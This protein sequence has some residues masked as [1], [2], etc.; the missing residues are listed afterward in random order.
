[1]WRLSHGLGDSCERGKCFSREY[2]DGWT[3]NLILWF[4][5]IDKT[6][7]SYAAIFGIRDDLKLVG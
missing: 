6:T 5:S 4:H 2:I 7:L 1:M 3:N